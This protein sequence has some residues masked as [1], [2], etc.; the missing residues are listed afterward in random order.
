MDNE[1]SYEVSFTESQWNIIIEQLI[2]YERAC[3]KNANMAKTNGYGTATSLEKA[4]E[5]ETKAEEVNHL[6][7]SIQ[8]QAL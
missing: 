8:E 1:R 5:W 2:R 7:T 3:H 6:L 4:R